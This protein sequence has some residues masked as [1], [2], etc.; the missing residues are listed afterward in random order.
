M[1]QAKERKPKS[2]WLDTKTT[3][4]SLAVTKI[5]KNRLKHFA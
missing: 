1:L 4:L 3:T 5:S 2:T